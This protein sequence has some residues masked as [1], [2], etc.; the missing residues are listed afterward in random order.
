MPNMD[1]IVVIKEAQKSVGT[2]ESG[3][4]SWTDGG[5]DVDVRI[6]REDMERLREDLSLLPTCGL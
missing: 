3:G 4:A 6:A 1:G 5:V 2:G